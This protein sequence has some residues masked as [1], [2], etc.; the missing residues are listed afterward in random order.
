MQELLKASGLTI[1]MSGLRSGAH[2]LW[3]CRFGL[4]LVVCARAV[5]LRARAIAPLRSTCL[6][7]CA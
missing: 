2:V 3:Q 4:M 5:V 1:W 6:D 7:H